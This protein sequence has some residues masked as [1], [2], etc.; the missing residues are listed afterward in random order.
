MKCFLNSQVLQVLPKL[1]LIAAVFSTST[2]Q[3]V[4]IK[5]VADIAGVRTNHLIGYGL[6]VGL[7]GTGDKTTQAPFTVQSLKN[8]LQQLG[9]TIPANVNPQL[10]NVAAVAVHAE[11]PPVCQTRPVDRCHGVIVG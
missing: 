9:V 6:V 4:R 11:L 1:L 5:D 7:P 3:A 2:V 10:K 8:M